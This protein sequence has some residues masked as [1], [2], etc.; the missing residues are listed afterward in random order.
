MAGAAGEGLQRVKKIMQYKHPVPLIQNFS[1]QTVHIPVDDGRS[2]AT[3]MCF[4]R[5]IA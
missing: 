3:M 5:D 4:K 1:Y 2:L